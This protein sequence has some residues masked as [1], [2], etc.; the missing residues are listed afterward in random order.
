MVAIWRS[1]GCWPGS[2]I[3][4]NQ[5]PYGPIPLRIRTGNLLLPCRELNWEIREI[6]KFSRRSGNP[7]LVRYFGICRQIRSSRQISKIVEK[8]NWDAAQMLEVTDADFELE[9]GVHVRPRHAG[10]RSSSSLTR[11]PAFRA[12]RWRH[13]SQRAPPVA[14]SST[15]I[16]GPRVRIPCGRAHD[17]A[18]CISKMGRYAAAGP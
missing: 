5:N 14:P 16:G 15:L 11:R 12:S 3:L 8:A 13:R 1:P 9:A 2:A 18:G 4:T 7:T 6:L 17:D 10:N